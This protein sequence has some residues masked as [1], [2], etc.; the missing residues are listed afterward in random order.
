MSSIIY[1]ISRNS[2]LK[3]ILPAQWFLLSMAQS[4]AP[5]Q[6]LPLLSEI[7]TQ[8]KYLEQSLWIF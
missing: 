2:A 4:K 3:Y 5:Q 8:I 6:T 1:S 7:I